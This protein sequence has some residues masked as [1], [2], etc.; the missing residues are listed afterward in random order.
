MTEDLFYKTLMDNLYDGVYF[1][2]RDRHITYWNKGA[3]RITGYPKTKVVGTFCHDNLLN[4][5]TENGKHLCQDGCPLL[6]TMQDGRPREAEVYLH[7]ADGY[8]LPVL[9]RT[10]PIRDESNNI[11]GA[12]EVFSN[13]KSLFKMRRKVDQLEQAIL[14]DPLT[15]VGNRAYAELKIKPALDEYKLQALPFALLFLDI[16]HFKSVNDVYGH[17]VGDMVLKNMANTLK[18]NLRGSDICGRWGGEEFIV[19]VFE[20]DQAVLESV[21]DKLR[22]LVETSAISIGGQDLYVTVSIG[23]TLVTKDDTLET[24]VHRADLL[25]YKSKAEGRN[26]ISCG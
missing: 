23:A 6:A 11:I 19:V 12:V 5:V 10:S 18:Y 1:V 26:R 16:D 2:D 3:E 20:V 17:N 24:L 8:R 9:M 22:S 4:H 7:H 21:A 13:N 14:V 15:G 25:M